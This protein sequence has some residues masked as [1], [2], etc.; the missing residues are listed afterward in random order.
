MEKHCGTGRRHWECR[1]LGVTDP[2]IQSSGTYRTRRV[3]CLFELLFGPLSSPSIDTTIRL[4]DCRCR[5]CVQNSVE[6]S[7]LHSSADQRAAEREIRFFFPKVSSVL[8]SVILS[9]FCSLCVGIFYRLP[10]RIVQL[11]SGHVPNEHEVK[12]FFEAKS[13]PLST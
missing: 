7:P 9:F 2:P 13:A 10:R 4:F 1:E 8:S 3:H 12:E 5:F 6:H 11:S